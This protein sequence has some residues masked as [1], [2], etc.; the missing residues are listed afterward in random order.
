M[1]KTQ[2]VGE[3]KI[4]VIPCRVRKEE[5]QYGCIQLLITLT[6]HVH[7]RIFILILDEV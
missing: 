6:I 4:I 3:T 7:C 1:N 5:R 2:P